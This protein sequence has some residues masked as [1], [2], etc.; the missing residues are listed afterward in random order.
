MIKAYSPEL[1]VHP[2]LFESA[3]VIDDNDRASTSGRR[4]L[5][6]RAVDRV[7]EW[8]PKLSCLVVG[9]GLGRDPLVL[10]QAELV[11]A[12]ALEMRVPLVVDA[13]GLWIWSNSDTFDAEPFKPKSQAV[14]LTPNAVELRR[15]ER[16][17]GENLS[18]SLGREVV[19]VEKGAMDRVCAGDGPPVVVSEGGSPRR[20]GGQGD[21]LAGC[22]GTF[23]S[24]AAAGA[25]GSSGEGEDSEAAEISRDA[26]VA[27][28]FAGSLLT[29]EASRAA[30]E[31]RGRSMVCGDV[32]EEVGPAFSRLFEA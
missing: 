9:P 15:L 4:E 28:A 2:Y 18:A 13:D 16:R 3:T 1:I 5:A 23:L 24:W 20:C 7:S 14:V 11:M 19:V 10:L 21:V 30:F 25:S 22:I 12:K 32:V 27:S 26:K 6:D 8:L 31:E 17:Y 29:R